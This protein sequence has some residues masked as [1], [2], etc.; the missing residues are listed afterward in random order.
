MQK[1]FKTPLLMVGIGGSLDVWS[2]EVKR[3]P[4]NISSPWFRMVVQNSMPARKN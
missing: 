4:K 1:S 2:G 3:A